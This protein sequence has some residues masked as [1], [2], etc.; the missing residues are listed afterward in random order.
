MALLLRP[1]TAD[2]IPPSV[3]A[4]AIE[5][6]LYPTTRPCTPLDV[7]L[8]PA[9]KTDRA[10]FPVTGGA[11]HCRDAT[12]A[13]SP[14]TRTSHPGINSLGIIGDSAPA[15]V[16]VTCSEEQPTPPREE[17]LAAL[18]G[19]FSTSSSSGDSPTPGPAPRTPPQP[20]S[21]PRTC[22]P[23]P[24]HKLPGSQGLA[25]RAVNT[26]ADEGLAADCGASLPADSK[27]F[28]A[29]SRGL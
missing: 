7:T 18:F 4:H 2:R 5:D 16:Y 19:S 1:A 29:A 14:G 12:G 20:S 21:A 27:P 15:R 10:A 25:Q 3:A 22:P 9:K 13:R 17:Q 6:F 28:Q 8:T 23:T 24:F 11:P 26:A